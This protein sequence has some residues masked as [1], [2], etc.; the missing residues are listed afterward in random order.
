MMDVTTFSQF[1]KI[2]TGLVEDTRHVLVRSHAGKQGSREAGR[3]AGRQAGR[4]NDLDQSGT[5]GVGEVLD[6]TVHLRLHPTSDIRHR[7]PI[8]IPSDDIG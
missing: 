1:S 7:H 3:Q 6:S 8:D 4:R 2:L 5:S